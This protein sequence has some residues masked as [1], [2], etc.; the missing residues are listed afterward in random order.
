MSQTEPTPAAPAHPW[1]P[2]VV[3]MAT[4]LVLT[5]LEGYLPRADGQ[6]HPSYYPLAYAG[7][8]A[9]VTILL[10]VFR[11]TWRDLW[12]LPGPGGG[13][14][15]VVLGIVVAVGWVGL[16]RLPYPRLGIVAGDRP[17]FNPLVLAPAARA[18]FLAVRFFGL[19]AMVPLM[20]ELFW[21][22]FLMRLV[23]DPD[24]DFLRVP[25]GRVTPAAAAI[26]SGLFAA[27]HPEWL[28][29]LLTA[30]AWAWLLARTGSLAACVLSHA[31]AN[32]GLGLYVVTTGHWELW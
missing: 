5:S 9:I 16:E 32:L 17:A 8:V 28:P 20:E 18:G 14:L 22:S 4:Y 19:V 2:Y 24:A 3:P 26:T 7:K 21:R 6:T 29:A 12:P 1:A 10:V 15:A 13:I 31:V 30:L 23:I 11:S 27:A 25:V